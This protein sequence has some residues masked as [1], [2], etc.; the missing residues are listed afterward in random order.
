MAQTSVIASVT[1]QD[2]RF[3]ALGVTKGGSVSDG[4][5]MNDDRAG[6]AKAAQ[7]TDTRIRRVMEAPIQ[8]GTI[9]KLFGL[10]HKIKLN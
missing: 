10:L 1:L 4:L 5:L 9:T 6:A 8:N 3:S 2:G 7:N